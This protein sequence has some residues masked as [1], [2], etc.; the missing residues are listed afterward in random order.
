M[1][2]LDR[3]IGS[4]TTLNDLCN[5]LYNLCVPNKTKD[6]NI[7]VFNMIKLGRN[8]KNKTKT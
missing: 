6:L 4:C 7:L 5:G 1:N 3:C 8:E 2:K